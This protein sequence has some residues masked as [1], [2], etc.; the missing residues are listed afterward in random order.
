MRRI[1]LVVADTNNWADERFRKP[2]LKRPDHLQM[3]GQT[4]TF[5]IPDKTRTPK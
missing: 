3:S 4:G 2:Q 5:A 1:R